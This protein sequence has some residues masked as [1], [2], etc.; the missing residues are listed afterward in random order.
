LWNEK[1]GIFKQKIP[2]R[3][4]MTNDSKDERSSMPVKE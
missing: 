1:Y 4:Q 3:T 2:S